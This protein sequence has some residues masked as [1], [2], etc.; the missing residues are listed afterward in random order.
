MSESVSTF[1]KKKGLAGKKRLKS[2]A[3]VH[4]D[5]EDIVALLEGGAQEQLQSRQAR[6]TAVLEDKQVQQQLDEGKR[7]NFYRAIEA[8]RT[9]QAAHE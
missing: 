7:A 4:D 1:R 8:K 2:E 3:V 6:H 9:K 5:D